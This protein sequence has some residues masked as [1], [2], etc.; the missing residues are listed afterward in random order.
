MPPPSDLMYRA[1]GTLLVP[2][3]FTNALI[4]L[5]SSLP[6]TFDSHL[7]RIT[8]QQIKTLDPKIHGGNDADNIPTLIHRPSP[9]K[10]GYLVIDD[11]F[12]EELKDCLVALE[13]DAKSEYEELC[14]K[15]PGVEEMR[16]HV[17]MAARVGW[18]LD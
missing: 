7:A 4:S 1:D 5:L 13:R 2:L 16:T 6:S 18:R 17:D 15:W 8:T 14:R 10:S 3:A 12:R 11:W 9:A